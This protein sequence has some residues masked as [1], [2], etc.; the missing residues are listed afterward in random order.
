MQLDVGEMEN[1]VRRRIAVTQARLHPPK[2][3]SGLNLSN[4][5]VFLITFHA[6]LEHL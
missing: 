5:E 4:F 2:S 1:R 3:T 6:Q